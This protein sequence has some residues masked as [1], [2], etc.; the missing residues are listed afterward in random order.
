[1]DISAM[2]APVVEIAGTVTVVAV[3][4]ATVAFMIRWI[5][6]SVVNV[7][8]ALKVKYFVEDSRSRIIEYDRRIKAMEDTIN[9]WNRRANDDTRTMEKS[10]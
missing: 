1:M 7:K 8:Y 5:I 2:I 10:E 9:D 3:C 4:V 6:K